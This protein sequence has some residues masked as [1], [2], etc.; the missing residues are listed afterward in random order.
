MHALPVDIQNRFHAILFG[1]PELL[2]NKLLLNKKFT[3]Q[4]YGTLLLEPYYTATD[5]KH[6]RT[7][8]E[9]LSQQV[10]PELKSVSDFASLEALLAKNSHEDHFEDKI[11]FALRYAL[12]LFSK[13]DLMDTSTTALI[14]Q[15]K[16]WQRVNQFSDTEYPF[17]AGFVSWMGKNNF[18]PV[19][20][21]YNLETVL[22]LKQWLSLEQW[23][24]LNK[25]KTY[26]WYQFC[27]LNGK[28]IASQQKRWHGV[29][30]L[31]YYLK[32]TVN[33][34]FK[35]P[36]VCLPSKQTQFVAR[37]ANSDE[38][39]ALW[40]ALYSAHSQQVEPALMLFCVIGLG[41]NLKTLPLL[42]TTDNYNEWIYTEQRPKRQGQAQ[43]KVIF[44]IQDSQAEAILKAY[45]KQ[46]NF[47]KG[48]PYLFTTPYS[49]KN[50]CPVSTDY[51]QRRV[52]TFVQ[53][54]LGY[55]LPVNYIER[56]M[57]NSL[58]KRTTLFEFM[59]VTKVIPLGKQTRM[60]TWLQSNQQV[61]AGFIRAGG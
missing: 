36:N 37:H 27:R 28:S 17:I 49:V 55:P 46:R 25:V 44:P 30:P 58:A 10:M 5:V 16:T 53:S 47:V 56:G 2:P 42:K 26:D 29:K 54:V 31:F 3:Q 40:Q 18:S 35:I 38:V 12:Q 32:A 8:L 14:T 13:Y 22:K 34:G 39:D 41:L 1:L 6:V 52:Q 45:I 15:L 61:A 57:L 23:Q 51:C 21:L 43:K 48:H 4:L 20:I 33:G 19:S 24:D 7:L 9:L 59:A 60:M 11:R 50:R